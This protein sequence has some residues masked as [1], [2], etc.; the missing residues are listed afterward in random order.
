MHASPVAGQSLSARGRGIAPVAGAEAAHFWCC[1]PQ[2]G[3]T[4]NRSVSGG[5]PLILEPRCDVRTCTSKPFSACEGR[6]VGVSLVPLRTELRVGC[7]L[8]CGLS[9]LF[10]FARRAAVKLAWLCVGASLDSD[11]F[12]ESAEWVS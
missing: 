5:L 7:L 3:Q 4:V 2:L 10:D 6:R 9:G 12:G 8:F 11:L 1:L